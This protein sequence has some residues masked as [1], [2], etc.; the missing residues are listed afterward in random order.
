FGT[1]WMSRISIF[2]PHLN[3]T[4]TVSM[5]YLPTGG[6]P[7][8][9]KLIDIPANSTFWS[10]NVLWDVFRV[11]QRGGSL[12][13]AT[14]PDDNPGV[15]DNVISRSFL[16][17]SDTFNNVPSGTYGQTIPGTFTGLMDIDTDGISSI[18]HGITNSTQFRWRT[19]VGAVNIGRCEVT[20]RVSVYDD[21]G[22]TVLNAAPFGVPPLGHIQH[23]LPVQVNSG[24]VEFWVEDPCAT[25]PVD[26]AVVFPYTS[27]ID[28]L[29]GDPR[30]QSPTLLASAGSLYNAKT[31]KIDP[32]SIGKKI[33]VSYAR[34]I[35]EQAERRGKAQ[36]VRTPT[37]WQVID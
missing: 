24:T 4:L 28:E 35:R 30:Y 20:L 10:D 7:G 34:G 16:V 21:E 2:N 11:S 31:A 3:Y 33:D 29:S 26:Y 17:T 6:S 15:P 22:R 13:L 19:N 12:L 25:H 37:G 32:H 8:I 27:T 14:F 18:S 1:N 9:E 23:L 5:T 36:L